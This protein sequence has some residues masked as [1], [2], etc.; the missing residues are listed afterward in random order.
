MIEIV[1]CLVL[2]AGF[3]VTALGDCSYLQS[4][5][6]RDPWVCA[7]KL[8]VAF[9]AVLGDDGKGSVAWVYVFP[10]LFHL[11][12]VA[13]SILYLFMSLL[14]SKII[15]VRMITVMRRHNKLL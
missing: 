6:S 8:T 14:I 5:A 13:H 1:P 10:F 7:Q 4:Q 11:F 15:R 9:T 12:L 2:Q 3:K